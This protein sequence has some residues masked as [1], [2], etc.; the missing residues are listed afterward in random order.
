MYGIEDI[1]AGDRVRLRNMPDKKH[2]HGSPYG[3]VVRVQGPMI[4]VELDSTGRTV[5]IE[6]EMI[7]E[8]I[9]G[10][11]YDTAKNHKVVDGLS[12]GTL[13]WS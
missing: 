6:P 2:L 3:D 5:R 13:R 4:L 9:S 7:T 1:Q 10:E 12:V 11:G 8:L